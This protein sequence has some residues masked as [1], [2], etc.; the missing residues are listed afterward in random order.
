MNK[1]KPGSLFKYVNNV[2]S[3]FCYIKGGM[4]QNHGSWQSRCIVSIDDENTILMFVEPLEYSKETVMGTAMVTATRCQATVTATAT[5][6]ATATL[7]MAREEL[8]ET[9]KIKGG[10]FLTGNKTIWIS[11]YDLESF[12]PLRK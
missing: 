1:I 8:K 10:I 6:M 4:I 7:V 5:G 9:G 11:H 12:R 3:R 2:E